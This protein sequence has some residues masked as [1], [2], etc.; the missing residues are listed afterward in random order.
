M[1]EPDGNLWVKMTDA[2]DGGD[3]DG[4]VG[5]REA[6]ADG[7]HPEALQEVSEDTTRLEPPS[8]SKPAT[9]LSACLERKAAS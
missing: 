5:D 3:A 9:E 2:E 1:F 8:P 4:G 6:D 7:G